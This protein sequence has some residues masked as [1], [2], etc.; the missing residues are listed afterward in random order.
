MPEFRLRDPRLPSHQRFSLSVLAALFLCPVSTLDAQ[1]TARTA[2]VWAADS[3]RAVA[4]ACK[5]VQ[6]LREEPRRYRCYVEAL[7]ETA[8]EYI[9]RVR[10]VP[11][12][13]T[14]PPPLSRSTVQI[15]KTDPSVTVTRIPDL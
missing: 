15:R 1:D 3:G 6:S 5:V 13:G 9:V 7:K 12:D 11:R 10:E 2:A 8:T 14:L 4:A